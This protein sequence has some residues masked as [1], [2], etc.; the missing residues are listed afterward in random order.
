LNAQRR[1]NRSGDSYVLTSDHFCHTRANVS[2]T[3]SSASGRLPVWMVSVRTSTG[4]IRWQKVSKPSGS[5]PGGSPGGPAY[6]DVTSHS[7]H[8]GGSG[9]TGVRKNLA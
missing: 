4:Y 7:T 6:G 9:F 1:A 2:W 3:K 5:S 8:T